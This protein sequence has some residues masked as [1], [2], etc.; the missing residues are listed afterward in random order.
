MGQQDDDCA[1]NAEGKCSVAMLQKKV[2][3]GADAIGTQESGAMAYMDAVDQQFRSN[4]ED[5]QEVLKKAWAL[6]DSKPDSRQEK[7]AKAFMSALEEQLKLNAVDGPEAFQRVMD[8][9]WEK[10]DKQA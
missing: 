3:R 10:F 7:G 2:Q 9:A 8:T 1:D 5:F 4:T 6:F